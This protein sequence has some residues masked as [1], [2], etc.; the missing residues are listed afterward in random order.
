MKALCCAAALLVGFAAEATTCIRLSCFCSGEDR[1]PV[2]AGTIEALLKT[3]SGPRAVFEIVRT[4]GNTPGYAIGSLVTT[5]RENPDLPG[6]R[7]LLFVLDGDVQTR[8]EISPGGTVTCQRSSPLFSLSVQEAHALYVGPACADAIEAKGLIYPCDGPRGC[9]CT[10][11]GADV[12]LLLGL[13]LLRI[14]RKRRSAAIHDR[15]WSRETAA[16]VAP[17][18]QE[19]CPSASR[20]PRRCASGKSLLVS[21]V[22][23][24]LPR[25]GTTSGVCPFTGTGAPPP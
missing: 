6:Q 11:P 24:A 23:V 25:L 20:W 13:G 3:V 17:S 5:Q 8:M 7:W 16:A 1:A 14:S 9:G 4:Q 22:T 10:A 15:R 18:P 19:S 21:P 2:S 12:G